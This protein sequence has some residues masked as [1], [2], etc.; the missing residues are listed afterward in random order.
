MLNVDPSDVDKL[1][2]HKE[3]PWLTLVTCRG[4]DEE[5]DRYRWRTLVR[6]VLV[7]VE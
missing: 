7:K 2:T 5:T 3:T 4:Y 1:M 6:A